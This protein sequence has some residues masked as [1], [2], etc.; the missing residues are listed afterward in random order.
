MK[1]ILSAAIVLVIL[2]SFGPATA[3]AGE[4]A[5]NPEETETIETKV[6]GIME[7]TT[8]PASSQIKDTIKVTPARGRTVDLQMYDEETKTWN[9]KAEF[10]A[11][12][13]E[14][15][16]VT[17]LYPKDWTQTNDSLW[18]LSIEAGSGAAA[19]VSKKIKIMTRNRKSLKLS[20]KSAIIMEKNSGQI[21]YAKAMD[22][23]RANASTTKMMTAILALENTDWDSKATISK[24]AV[25]TPYTT[26]K[27]K[28]GDTVRMKHLAY[29]ALVLSDNGSA[30]AL[31]EHTAGNAASFASM[32][33]EKAEEL[34]CENTHF[35]NPHGL[36]DS[37]HYSTARDLAIIGGYAMNNANFRKIVKTKKYS[38]KTLTKKKSYSFKTTNKLLGETVGIAGVK[39]GTTG[40]AGCCFVGAYR[41]KGNDYMT[42]VLGAQKNAQRWEDTKTLIRYIKKYI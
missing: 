33:N 30:T 24:N 3:F 1:R 26:L 28:T 25:K 20:A 38:F 32:M 27:Y 7:D 18:R 19:Y 23:R 15:E 8:K 39:T 31:A 13:G 41:Y 22:T 11:G 36:D 5:S 35:V 10:T 21:F 42:V 17:I 37:E 2:F 14:T 12:P 29:A 9:T 4:E 16:K 6:S 34:G 40:K